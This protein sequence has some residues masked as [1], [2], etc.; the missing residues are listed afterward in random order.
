MTKVQLLTALANAPFN[1]IGIGTPVNPNSEG[2]INGITKYIVSVFETG[3]SQQNQQP[4][5]YRKNV[6]FYV[7]NESL[8][9][10]AA[11]FEQI[12][13]VNTSNTDPSF[14]SSSYANIAK[15]YRTTSL[16]DRVM[17][18]IMTQCSVVFQELPSTTDHAN[19][20]LLVALT[21]KDIKNVT[22]KFMTAIA[23]NATIQTSGN[24]VADSVIT[25]IVSGA[26][27]SYA[28]LQASNYTQMANS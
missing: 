26:W 18:A 7:Y 28:D 5:G 12:E 6:V 19:R 3:K 20:M 27:N 24:T 1:Y 22:M 21:N 23:L 9:D 2:P 4:T 11:Y 17:A 8:G 16:Q 13:P 14:S 15:L 10:E 25:S